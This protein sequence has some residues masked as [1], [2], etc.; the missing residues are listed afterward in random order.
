MVYRVWGFKDVI[1]NMENQ[2]ERTTEHET[3]TGA[4]SLM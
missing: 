2:M 3:G 4:G 1:P